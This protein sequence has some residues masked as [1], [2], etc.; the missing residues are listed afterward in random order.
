MPLPSSGQISLAD[1]NAELGRSA[2][3][4]IGMY[5]AE[6]GDY[7]AINQYSPSRP[8]G[9]TPN[10]ITEWYNYNHSIIGVT[11]FYAS[12]ADVFGEYELAVS[13]Y[14]SN[15]VN[16]DTTIDAIVNTQFGT[17]TLTVVI[18]NG[19]SNGTATM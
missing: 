18:S 19:N 1:I 15:S 2:N 14:L 3:T 11:G 7:G 17:T 6:N 5:Q 4:Q 13:V 9:A 8:F 12:S 16:Q 10:E